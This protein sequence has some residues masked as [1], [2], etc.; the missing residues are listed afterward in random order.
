[1]GNDI[2]CLE[3]QE[4]QSQLAFELSW[5]NYA[6]INI[7]CCIDVYFDYK[8]N[9]SSLSEADYLKGNLMHL[10]KTYE[11]EIKENKANDNYYAYMHLL[12]CMDHI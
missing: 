8:I 7:L 6:F 1:M 12:V 3:L 2:N 9:L 10:K 4:L 11:N 5:W